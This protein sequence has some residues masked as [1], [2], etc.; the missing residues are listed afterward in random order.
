[1]SSRFL[2]SLS[3]WEVAPFFTP[4]R[5][6]VPL[7][8]A[9]LFLEVRSPEAGWLSSDSSL[10]DSWSKLSSIPVIS[11]SEAE[12]HPSWRHHARSRAVTQSAKGPP[13]ALLLAV[14]R[15]V[16]GGWVAHGRN[17]HDV[18]SGRLPGLLDDPRQ[19][20]ILPHRFV[21]DLLQHVLGEIQALLPLVGS[22]H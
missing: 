19:R 11:S 6:L 22:A 15:C 20:A 12:A 9:A 21:H 2:R 4:L 13:R 5:P 1:M 16:T 3:F 7:F 10:S 18:F 17:S 8:G 14:G